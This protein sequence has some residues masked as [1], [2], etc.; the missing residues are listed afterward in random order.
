MSFV[1][2]VCYERFLNGKF[3]WVFRCFDLESEA[4]EFYHDM[5]N[6]GGKVDKPVYTDDPWHLV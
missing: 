3:E 6:L 1:Y 4:W 5:R 2:A